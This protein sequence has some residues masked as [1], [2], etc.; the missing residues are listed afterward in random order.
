[1]SEEIARQAE[2]ISAMRRLHLAGVV[3]LGQI[4]GYLCAALVLSV[5]GLA[6]QVLPFLNSPALGLALYA[7]TVLPGP[8]L[9][10]WWFLKRSGL[11]PRPLVVCIISYLAASVVFIW[12]VIQGDGSRH[13]FGVMLPRALV[14]MPLASIVGSFLSSYVQPNV[15]PQAG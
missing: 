1:V 4:A 8:F 14:M 3:L 2:T 5:L 7:I 10:S 12:L 11:H 13:A 6:S 9:C 15:D